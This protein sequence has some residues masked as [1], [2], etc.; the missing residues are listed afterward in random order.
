MSL[1]EGATFVLRY[2]RARDRAEIDAVVG[3]D[4]AR[5][6]FLDPWL[7]TAVLARV[8]DHDGMPAAVI[9]VHEINACTVSLSMFATYQWRHVALAVA[10]W[11]RRECM[12]QL[13]AAGYRR[14]ECRAID[15]HEDAQAFLKFLGFTLEC[16]C[17][18]YGRGGETFLQFAWR[19]NDHVLHAENS[20]AAAPGSA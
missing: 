16:R 12:P 3:Y 15:G 7:A 2:C 8:F 20:V 11:A 5:N 4:R 6:G 14:A 9:A 1:L 19:A 18:E 13:L 17:P 10:K